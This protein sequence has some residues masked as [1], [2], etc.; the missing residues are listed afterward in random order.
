MD[1]RDEL[2]HTIDLVLIV[3]GSVTVAAT[4]AATRYCTVLGQPRP[5]LFGDPQLLHHVV[6]SL[7]ISKLFL[8]DSIDMLRRSPNGDNID[9]TTVILWHNCHIC[10]LCQMLHHEWS[11]F[12]CFI[13]L[14][15][16]CCTCPPRATRSASIRF[17]CMTM[18]PY[19]QFSVSDQI[20][21][22]W[23]SARRP[24]LITTRF[25]ILQSSSTRRTNLSQP[26]M[27]GCHNTNIATQLAGA[28]HDTTRGRPQHGVLRTRP[29][30]RHFN[31]ATLVNVAD[32]L[33]RSCSGCVLGDGG[34]GAKP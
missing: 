2:G 14:M 3:T 18:S 13:S 16:L 32:T 6:K 5:V 11:T 30:V 23:R 34:S 17:L 21:M 10:E 7:R 25:E 19:G 12:H 29:R 24:A 27:S 22:Y 15:P 31:A 26:F 20:W 33:L 8:P 1:L 9:L 28:H 4:P